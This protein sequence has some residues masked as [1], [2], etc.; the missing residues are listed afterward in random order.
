V[1]AGFGLLSRY[2]QVA[3][4]NLEEGGIKVLSYNVRHFEGYEKGEPKD[5]AEKIVDFLNE[6]EP[7]IICFQ[8]TRLRRNTIFN[9]ANTVKQLKSI[10]HYHYAR[11]GSTY[12][13]VTMTRYPII[14]MNEI[15]FENS[16]NM[17]ISTDVII[18]KDTV[19]IFNVHLQS[20][21]IDPRKYSIIESPGIDEE[22]DI[23]EM[24]DMGKKLA[25]A[26]V[27]RA[28]QARDVKNQINKSPYPVIVCGDFNDTP[29][30]YAYQT[31]RG[32]FIDAFISSGKGF[33][34]TYVGKLPSFRIDNI[35]H[36]PQFESYNF[37]TYGFKMSDH[38]PVSC[39]LVLQQN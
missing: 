13:L 14:K 37:K 8:E 33:G 35:F 7:D 12:G 20:Y 30:S 2:F 27:I 24:R 17:A 19:R 9:L 25:T 11:S 39:S 3:G 38:L 21:K 34:Q 16:G 31:M 4:K 6:Q 18:K 36:S 32:D 29:V 28:K 26:F 1:V 10:E 5:N 23:K 15:R 22:K